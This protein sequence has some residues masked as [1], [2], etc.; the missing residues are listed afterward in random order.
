MAQH[1]SSKD[2]QEKINNGRQSAYPTPTIAGLTQ[3]AKPE[4]NQ[5]AQAFAHRLA[6]VLLAASIMALPFF[7]FMAAKSGAWQLTALFYINIPF[8]VASSIGLWLERRGRIALSISLM[9]GVMG[10]VIVAAS[11]LISGIGIVAGLGF[12]LLVFYTATRTLSGRDATR[13]NIFSV[14]IGI[15]SIAASTFSQSTQISVPAVQVAVPVMAVI[16][17]VVAG[18][19]V[20]RQFSTYP[21]R[22]KLVIILVGVALFS[23]TSVAFATNQVISQ[24]IRQQAGANLASLAKGK[25]LEIGAMLNRDKNTLE[26][27]VINE[28]LQN[29]L[30]AANAK[31]T[32][33]P[34][35]LALLDEQWQAA[36]DDAD[37]IIHDALNNNVAYELREYQGRFPEFVEIFLTNKYG[38]NISSTN[39]TT[40]YY[41]ADEAWWQS[42]WNNG[43][44]GIYISQPQLDESTGF[45]AIDIAMPVYY[46]NSSEIIGI[47]RATVDVSAFKDTL[48][49]GA[50]GHSGRVDL[51]FPSQT[52]IN[53]GLES[54]ITSLDFKSANL[55]ASLNEQFS[56]FNFEGQPSLISRSIVSTSNT[57]DKQA[58]QTLGWYVV[59]H[60]DI[61]EALAPADTTVRIIVLTAL[62]VLLLA[63]LLAFYL[64]NVLTK[65]LTLLTSVATQVAEGN[66]TVQAPV[67]SHDEIGTLTTTFNNMTGQLHTLIG[68]MEQRIAERTRDLE[69]ASEV[70]RSVSEKVADLQLLLADSVEL[71]RDRF[72]LYYTQIYLA[73]ADGRTLKLRAGT[74]D[75]G[76]TLLQRGHHLQIGSGSLNGRAASN[77]QAVIVADTAQS[78][79]FLP[80]PLL[81]NT[82]SEMAV[83]LISGDRVVGVLDMQSERPGALSE[84]ELSAFETLAAQLAIAIQNA[85]LFAES[86]QSKIE[87]EA[88][89]RRLTRIGWQD[90][91]DAVERS[92]QLGYVFDQEQVLPLKSAGLVVDGPVFTVPIMVTGEQVGMLQIVTGSDKASADTVEIVRSTASLLANQIENLRLFDQAERYRVEAEE[93]ARRLT[94]EGWE[95][96][97]Q[98]RQ[99]LADGYVYDLNAVQPVSMSSNGRCPEFARPVVVRD[100]IIG[101]LAVDHI[102]DR[103]DEAAQIVAAVAEQL[104]GHIENLRLLEEAEQRRIEVQQGEARLAEALDLAKLGHW[105]Y[106]PARDL[107]IFNDHFYSILHTTAEQEG[108]YT[109]SST[110][111]AGTVCLSRGHPGGRRRDRK[112]PHRYR[113]FI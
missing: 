35:Y 38:G 41:Q 39:R 56:T 108:G 22:T 64:G 23:I 69:L 89:A 63:S 75:V 73:E 67:T 72:D 106:D 54:G 25:A 60:Q 1:P 13:V 58:I 88:Q 29:D 105:E 17:I 109:M 49:A 31:S 76:R 14:V 86:Q 110:E 42:A 50:F 26:S 34:V 8:A 48:R 92:E 62:V 6:L 18:V 78:P 104:S 103:D 51:V 82:R 36:K 85:T 98:S 20:V 93:S 87:V 10:L 112:S 84:T 30:K 96:Y 70:G 90:F 68:S 65:P 102:N 21:L 55:L 66:L 33:D 5:Q 61:A 79:T 28:A 77:R 52:V 32:S 107:F 47:L 53:G 57:N 43:M 11:V 15:A 99:A 101:E 81:P 37:P 24:Q 9:L 2:D 113:T 12:P 27:L 16:L 95:S 83:P 7:Y 46:E 71:I 80:N 100:E 74:G 44:G 40:D 45:Y 3:P 97:L 111:Y 4:Q 19:T 91:L 94:R 59:A